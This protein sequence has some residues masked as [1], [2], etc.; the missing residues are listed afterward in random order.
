MKVT[1]VDTVLRGVC[2]HRVTLAL[3]L[4]VAGSAT[5]GLSQVTSFDLIEAT[6]PEMQATME[7][8]LIDSEYLV[9]QYLR[10]IEAFDTSGPML[11][12][13]LS[14]NPEALATA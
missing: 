6:I 1:F 11:R 4:V 13:V 9:R 10:R 12:S 7:A 3:L 8:G 5:R 14:L 2:E